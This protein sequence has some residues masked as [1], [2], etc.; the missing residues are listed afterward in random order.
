[1]G[2]NQGGQ[3]TIVRESSDARANG[4]S[5]TGPGDLEDHPPPT[6]HDKRAGKPGAEPLRNDEDAV[7]S[8]EPAGSEGTTRY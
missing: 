5:S 1:M 7:G 3:P 8:T 2:G 6:G 4:G